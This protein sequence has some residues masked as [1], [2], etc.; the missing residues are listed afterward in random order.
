MT[1]RTRRLGLVAAL[2]AI[3]AIGVGAWWGLWGSTRFSTD[4]EAPGPA[5]ASPPPPPE[6]PRPDST[7]EL[8]ASPPTRS[9]TSRASGAEAGN[10]IRPPRVYRVHV[11]L[12]DGT[13]ATQGVVEAWS[14]FSNNP[15]PMD[16]ALERL[17]KASIGPGGIAEVSFARGSDGYESLLIDVPGRPTFLRRSLG[18]ADDVVIRLPRCE[19]VPL[20]GTVVDAAGR[21]LP[22][23]A[24]LVTSGTENGSVVLDS[25]LDFEARR[26]G[27]QG[28]R[29]LHVEAQ[30]DARGAFVV[31]VPMGAPWDRWQAVYES[32]RIVSR[33]AAWFLSPAVEY[34]LPSVGGEATPVVAT[35]VPAVTLGVRMSTHRPHRLV[36]P[37]LAA[38]L[39][40]GGHGGWRVEL[41]LPRPRL[42][43]RD[44]APFEMNVAVR[45]PRP[46]P[47]GEAFELVVAAS[48]DGLDPVVR[49]VAFPA[50]IA[51]GSVEFALDRAEDASRTGLV[52]LT[53][54]EMS[55]TVGTPI[56]HSLDI[57]TGD[58]TALRVQ[59][60]YWLRW[61][62]EHRV[63]VRLPPGAWRLRLR[64]HGHLD[65][66]VAEARVD[67]APRVTTRATMEVPASR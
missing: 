58:D 33:D 47:A 65:H 63:D 19:V 59:R 66:V 16:W 42:E 6:F 50:G 1:S 18:D 67:V 4:G 45:L 62:A 60:L 37:W 5:P 14:T 20:T 57:A 7:S 64:P 10:A 12:P 28:I 11:T 9:A 54:P 56:G 17:A 49:R 13:D 55:G 44:D 52:E 32:V 2:V 41:D 21:G 8:R 22:N 51:T 61:T 53:L 31:A 15:P 36:G 38:G 34:A 26:V 46:V 23:L 29:Y 39:A 25:D 35:A 27:R 43:F 3:V 40:A 24:I 48:A 30:T